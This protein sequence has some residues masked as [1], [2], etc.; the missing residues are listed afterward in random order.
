[1]KNILQALYDSFLQAAGDGGVQRSGGGKP[2]TVAGAVGEGRSQ[3]CAADRGR[4]EFDGA[5]AVLRQLYL[6][7]QAGV[8]ADKRT[9]SLQGK[10]ALN[11]DRRCRVGRSLFI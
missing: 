6:R 7:T 1:M 5:G 4:H 9:E 2:F 11:T 3:D 10:R 8:A